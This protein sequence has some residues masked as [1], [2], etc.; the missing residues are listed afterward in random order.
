MKDLN[1]GYYVFSVFDYWAK[2][3][4]VNCSGYSLFK[5]TECDLTRLIGVGFYG[6]P[7]LDSILDYLQENN[8]DKVY[9]LNPTLN[10]FLR[11]YE[12]IGG[13]EDTDSIIYSQLDSY[14]ISIFHNLRIRVEIINGVS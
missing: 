1:N 9:T 4:N 13:D 3:N 14:D 6:A 7:T 5:L 8:I 12:V 2:R 10:N 11:G